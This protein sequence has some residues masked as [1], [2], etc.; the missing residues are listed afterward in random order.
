LAKPSAP[1]NEDFSDSPQPD[2]VHFQARWRTQGQKST[3]IP[4]HAVGRTIEVSKPPL[5]EALSLNTAENGISTSSI[6]PQQSRQSTSAR[7]HLDSRLIQT[8]HANVWGNLFLDEVSDSSGSSGLDQILKPKK[9]FT[10]IS[11]TT[12][13]SL[14]YLDEYIPQMLGQLHI[15]HRQRRTAPGIQCKHASA[16]FTLLVSE[17]EGLNFNRIGIL[18]RDGERQHY[19][20]A[21]RMILSE[22]KAIETDLAF[23]GVLNGQD[24]NVARKRLLAKAS[25]VEM[26]GRRKHSASLP[27]APK[28]LPGNIRGK[29]EHPV[30]F[31]VPDGLMSE[32][33]DQR[34]D[35]A[36]LPAVPKDSTTELRPKNPLPF[37]LRPKSFR[38]RYLEWLHKT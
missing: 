21:V 10:P 17:G 23:T 38:G 31:N 32:M 34:E 33:G 20:R 30:T 11:T 9:P 1:R 18:Y 12:A 36:T 6:H 8:E 29:Q 13:M 19:E 3:Q 2:P 35:F 37:H 16:L 5:V 26:N 24:E 27:P 22:L 25:M 4:A 7:A 28:G 15:N 14:S